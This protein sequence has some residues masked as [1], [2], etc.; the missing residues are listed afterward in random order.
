[1]TELLPLMTYCLVMSSTPGPNNVL[2]TTTGANHGYRGAMPQIL[3][4]N[5]GVAVQTLL[6]CLGLGSLFNSY[7]LAQQVLQVVGTAY[8]VWLAW[9]LGRSSMVEGQS[10]RPLTFVQSVTFQAVNPKSWIKAVT[11]ASVFMPSGL[12]VPAGAVLVAAI[13][14]LI[15]FPCSSMWAL[16]GVAIRGWLANPRQQRIFNLLMAGTLLLLAAKL[17][18]KS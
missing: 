2:L 12:S 9:R 8:L 18:L 4:A 1:M 5:S 16:F 11:L 13:G 14:F 10:A 17:F 15:G 3:G 6:C 7:P